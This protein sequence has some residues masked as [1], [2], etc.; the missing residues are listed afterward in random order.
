MVVS[1]TLSVTI[2]TGI[3]QTLLAVSVLLTARQLGN[4][5][6][7]EYAASFSAAGLASVLFNL[8]LDTWLLQCGSRDP[9]KLGILTGSAFALKA[10]I[11]LPWLIGIILIF[12]YLNPRVFNPILVLISGLSIWIEGFFAI[13]KSVFQALL[14][15]RLMVL[16]L[17]LARSGVLLAT[18]MLVVFDVR[19]SIA[20]ALIRLIV[21]ILVVFGVLP[22]IPFKPK[23]NSVSTLKIVMGES[24]PFALSDIFSL[25]YLQADVTIAAIFLDKQ[26]VGLYAP[27]SGF[28]NALF[29]IPNAWF[30]VAVPIL[31][32]V[33]R[34]D[35]KS[36]YR[37]SGLMGAGFTAIGI[38]LWLSVQ[39]A[40]SILP[41]LVLGNSFER[42]GYLM[43]ILSPII[44]LK[45]CN[46][47]AAAIL[48]SVGWQN[49]RVYVQAAS[50]M[51]NV[52]LNLAVIRRLG[53]T[54]VAIVYVIS[55]A[56]LLIG[57]ISLVIKWMHYSC[58]LPF[59]SNQC[60][61][62]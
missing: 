41:K 16:F 17:V 28:I 31:V 61:S 25:I 55:E 53:V 32:R 24:V 58:T 49:Q 21:A 37:M 39:C 19:D 36:F 56:I 8:G 50:A 57:Y 7:G 44:L 5:R 60:R 23:I 54:G 43:T 15:H 3:A 4:V 26:E 62:L 42:S 9:E 10:L 40:S 18:I 48:V 29:V 13:E 6:F 51:A 45:S 20:Y 30:F 47:A 2:G 22:F 11:G 33:L 27:A 38:A 12:P 1:N 34:C 35:K 59:I 52:A 14:R 46:F